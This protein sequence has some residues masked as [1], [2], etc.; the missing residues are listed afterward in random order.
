MDPTFRAMCQEIKFSSGV[1]RVY[2]RTN[3]SG[4]SVVDWVARAG[5]LEVEGSFKN[6]GNDDDAC[7]KALFEADRKLEDAAADLR[8][9]ATAIRAWPP[10]PRRLDSGDTKK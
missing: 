1:L 9:L 7:S 10:G 6:P 8:A 4:E 2:F 5:D 3:H